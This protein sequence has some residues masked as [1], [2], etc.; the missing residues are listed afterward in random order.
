[1]LLVQIFYLCIEK[2]HKLSEVNLNYEDIFI[3]TKA[4]KQQRAHW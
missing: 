1:M 3:T 4:N 2:K